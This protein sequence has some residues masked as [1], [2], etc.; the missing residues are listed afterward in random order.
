[1]LLA[2]RVPMFLASPWTAHV[3]VIPCLTF[4]ALSAAVASGRLTLLPL[5]AVFASFVAQ[6]HVGFVPIVGAITVGVLVCCALDRTTDRRL[7]WSMIK[8]SGWI[9]VALWLVPIAESLSGARSNA[10]SLWRFFVTEAGPGHSLREALITWSYGLTGVLRPDLILGWGG[11]FALSHLSWA[12]PCAL[13]Q[14]LVLAV[15]ARSDLRR[16]CRFEGC[17]AIVALAASALA[18]WSL[19]R[20]RGDILDHDLFRIAALGTLNLGIIA[21]AALRV[22]F[23]PEAHAWSRGTLGAGVAYLVVF[24]VAL[25]VGQ[26]DLSRLTSFERRRTDRKAIVTGYAAIRHYVEAEGLH[27]PLFRI[28]NDKWGNA[29]GILLRLRQ[30]GTAAAVQDAGL[31]MFPR[32]FAVTGDEDALITLANLDLHRVVRAQPDTVVLQ[33]FGPLFVDAARLAPRPGR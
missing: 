30:D 4:L 20:I 17:L 29:A 14:L 16:N 12:V 24:A 27:K 31:S 2:W 18:L 13:G 10:A 19:T 7:W 28:D 25:S 23:D 8:R 26:R 3:P 11:H 33:S 9:S 21:A 5:T 32:V 6:T 15:I 1:V 22:V